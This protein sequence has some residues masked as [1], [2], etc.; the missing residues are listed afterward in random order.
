MGD[1]SMRFLS[2]TW[3]QYLYLIPNTKQSFNTYL[4]IGPA[5]KWCGGSCT[6][7]I[8]W[9]KL[10]P[11]YD[12]ADDE[13]RQRDFVKFATEGRGYNS[14]YLKQLALK[15]IQIISIRTNQM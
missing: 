15:L 7:W 10:H 6:D 8:E 9:T 13:K 3:K 1:V 2:P 11:K 5:I 14:Y 12:K 4:S